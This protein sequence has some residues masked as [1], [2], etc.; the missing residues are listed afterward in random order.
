M[1]EHRQWADILLIAPMSADLMSKIACGISDT[2]LLSVVRAWH[3][4]KKPIVV[5]PAM[6]TEM[7][8]HPTTES[9]LQTFQTWGYKIVRPVSKLLACNEEGEGA[10]ADV[11]TIVDLAVEYCSAVNIS[12]QE[13]VEFLENYFKE[14]E[15]C[16][17]SSA[18]AIVE[19]KENDTVRQSS[20]GLFCLASNMLLF[21]AIGGLGIAATLDDT[22]NV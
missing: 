10:L 9:A 15:I 7:F 5:C 12:S 1:Y 8:R 17:G 16:S 14:Q 4:K 6:N 19:L 3:L 2:L 13:H 18:G 21:V 22:M 20:R 11:S